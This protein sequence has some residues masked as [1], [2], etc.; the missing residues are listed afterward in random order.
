MVVVTRDSVNLRFQVSRQEVVVE[1]DSVVQGLV[2]TF[3]LA[4]CL[5]MVRRTTCMLHF[6]V[7]KV[8][9]Q[10]VRDVRWSVVG[11]QARAVHNVG[12]LKP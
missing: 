9:G 2:Q 10:V 8:F 7:G 5:R 3:H 11:Q 1:Q 12:L 4:L 6:L